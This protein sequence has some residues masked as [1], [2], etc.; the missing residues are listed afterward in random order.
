MIWPHPDQ[1]EGIGA[2]SNLIERLD[3]IASAVTMSNRPTTTVI[4][5]PSDIPKDTVLK[6]THSDASSHVILPT[7][8]RRRTWDLL[9][10]GPPGSIW[11]S[12]TYVPTLRKLGEFRVFLIGGQPTYVMHT[13]CVKGSMWV[14]TPQL[15]FLTLN[16]IRYS[17][18]LCNYL[19]ILIFKL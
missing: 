2:K 15:M 19:N 18:L 3:V 9:S 6:R 11:L 12:Q 7:A 16:E 4:T 17:L 5:K 13:E 1:V 10:D 8:N 14:A